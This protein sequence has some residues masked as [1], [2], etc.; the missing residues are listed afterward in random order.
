[1]LA[2]NDK[3]REINRLIKANTK[4]GNQYIMRGTKERD[5]NEKGVGRGVCVENEKC[6][7]TNQKDFIQ[8][9]RRFLE[10]ERK[11]KEKSKRKKEIM[12]AFERIHGK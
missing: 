12:A 10:M 2:K 5:K 7:S 8:L 6:C 9:L 4:R 11:K 3:K 1:M